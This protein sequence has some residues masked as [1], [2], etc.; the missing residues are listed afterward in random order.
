MSFLE[1]HTNADL[2]I[3]FLLSLTMNLL[4]DLILFTRM[5]TL[6]AVKF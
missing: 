1:H 6:R 4:T 5:Q 3:Y 2:Y